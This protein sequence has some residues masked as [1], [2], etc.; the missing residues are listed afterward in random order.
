VRARDTDEKAEQAQLEIYRGMSGS[1]RLS[2]AMQMSDATRATTMAGIR[3]RHPDYT[4]DQ[5]RYALFRL[6]H[7]DE[8]FRRAWPDAP[9]LAP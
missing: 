6:L 5:V 3:A 2:L 4:D 8:L 1:E 9:L 7:G